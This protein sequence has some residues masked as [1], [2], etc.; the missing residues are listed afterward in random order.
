MP[1][2]HPVSYARLF[3]DA[4]IE[5]IYD[6]AVAVL[7][8]TGFRIQ[9]PILLARLAQRGA[10]VDETSQVFWPTRG[11]M[12]ELA[13]CLARQGAEHAPVPVLRRPVPQGD[14]VV[15]NAP[16]YY[17]AATGERRSATLRDVSDVLKACHELPEVTRM[18]PALAASDVPY[19]VEPLVGVAEAIRTTDKE[20]LAVE[21]V[22]AGQ[23]PFMEELETIS[24]GQQV[25]YTTAGTSIDRFTIDAR[26]AQMLL[27]TWR[28]NGLKHWWVASCATAGIT[29]PVT[30]AGAVTVG[31]AE[32]LGGWL[33]GWVL[34][35]D[36]TFSISP[37]SSVLDMRSTRVLFGARL[38]PC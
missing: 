22:L 21:L 33:A 15:Y 20:V 3:S 12:D 13:Q 5:R 23:L 37:C 1:D 28:R 27:T 30:L 17:D 25:R 11:M 34:D 35:A 29:A 10:R 36:V 16:L 2:L 18:G 4:E 8:D 32:T 24:R 26:G 9:E 19:A 6:G 14:A 38:R 7:L 31:V